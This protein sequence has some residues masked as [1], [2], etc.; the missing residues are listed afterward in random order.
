MSQGRKYKSKAFYNPLFRMSKQI[1]GEFQMGEVITDKYG[2]VIN[3]ELGT[4]PPSRDLGF[5]DVLDSYS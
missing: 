3:S 5:D 4:T 2:N 1:L